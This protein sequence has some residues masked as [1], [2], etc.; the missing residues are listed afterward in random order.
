MISGFGMAC[1]PWGSVC[2][3]GQTVEARRPA[4][5]VVVARLL[6][7]E[8]PLHQ[9]EASAAW[10]RLEVHHDLGLV[11]ARAALVF[12][13]PCEHE[14]PRRL[15]DAIDAAG[16]QHAAVGPAQGGAPAAAGP[17]VEGVNRGLVTFRRPPSDELSGLGPER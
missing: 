1:L 11:A 5:M 9:Y 14:T 6:A 2:D 12:P 10:P 7:L 17:R 16:C 8:A 13:G 4:G 15:D 3:S